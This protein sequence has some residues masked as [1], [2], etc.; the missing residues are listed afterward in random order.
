MAGEIF[1]NL[2]ID[3]LKDFTKIYDKPFIHPL[4]DAALKKLQKMIAQDGSN[5]LVCLGAV[6][7]SNK[8]QLALAGCDLATEIF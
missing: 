7:S 2:N 6:K 1:T 8:N 3:I 4:N 5:P